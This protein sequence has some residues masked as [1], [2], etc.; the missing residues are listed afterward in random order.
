M[1]EDTRTPSSTTEPPAVDTP[2][3]R[4][5][6]EV[7]VLV[8]QEWLIEPEV[9]FSRE[10]NKRVWCARR[11]LWWRLSKQGFGTTEIAVLFERDH[12][13]VVASLKRSLLDKKAARVA[14]RAAEAAAAKAA[15][16]GETRR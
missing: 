5:A 10:R 7:A 6:R 12:S 4:V 9:L 11:E 14:E 3:A 15:K 2:L 8:A 13:T 1:G 16:V